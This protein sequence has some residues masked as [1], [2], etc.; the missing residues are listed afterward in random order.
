MY[1]CLCSFIKLCL[2]L[3]NRSSGHG[4]LQARILERVAIS[5]FLLQGIFLT[6]GSYPHLCIGRQILYP[7][8]TWVAHTI[9]NYSVKRKKGLLINT[10]TWMNLE[11]IIHSEKKSQCQKIPVWSQYVTFLQDKT[12]EIENKAIVAEM[13]GNTSEFFHGAGTVLHFDW[14]DSYTI[15]RMG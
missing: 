9:Q 5:F 1:L 13:K 7:W 10:T 6:Q 2:I 3:S 15:I 12:V 8:A 4:I 11:G 14:G